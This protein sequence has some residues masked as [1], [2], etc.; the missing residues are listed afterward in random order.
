MGR[1]RHRLASLSATAPLAEIGGLRADIIR[2][3]VPRKAI[4]NSAEAAALGVPLA[5]A[6]REGRE[7]QRIIEAG[8]IGPAPRRTQRSHRGAS[9]KNF[10]KT[11]PAPTQAPAILDNGANSAASPNLTHEC[12]VGTK[13][14]FLFH[15]ARRILFWQAKREWGAHFPQGLLRKSLFRKS[16]LLTAMERRD[17]PP[18]GTSA[19]HRSGSG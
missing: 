8:Q 10:S 4:G 2:P 7:R 11:V 1:A 13:S 3:P 18:A 17:G 15:R 5:P 19:R 9:T 12:Q 6:I 16:G 14:A